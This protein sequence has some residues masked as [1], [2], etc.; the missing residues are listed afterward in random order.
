MTENV[1]MTELAKA[2]TERFFITGRIPHAIIIEG[3]S[4]ENRFLAALNLAKAMLC[5]GDEIPCGKCK[6][7]RKVEAGVHPD[8]IV[9]EKESSKATMGVDI[10]RAMKSDVYIK[11]NDSDNKVYIFKEAQN[12]TPQSQNALLKVFEEPP[13]HVSVILTCSSK[14]TLLETI[15]SRGT[16]ITLGEN[17]ESDSNDGK[18]AQAREKANELLSSLCDENELQ[19]MLKTAVFEKDKKLLSPVLENMAA[20]F[21]SASVI[22]S[23]GKN[24]AYDREIS[25]K[26]S[27]KFTLKQLVGFTDTVNLLSES[28]MKN[29]NNNLTLT[30]LSSL[31]MQGRN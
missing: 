9:C 7:C 19:F 18:I 16:V 13:D 1:K 20:A 3:T 27:M 14:A 24:I 21:S 26:L 11:A 28:V 8:V 22:K 4:C 12:M 17:D 23:G 29:A 10:I 31:L 5:E 6:S 25:Q 15:L 30:R 2:K